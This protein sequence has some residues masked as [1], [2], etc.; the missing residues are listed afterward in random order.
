MNILLIHNAYTTFGGEDKVVENITKILKEKGHQ[1]YLFK[2]DSAEITNTPIGNVRAFFSG[3]YSWKSKQT[4]RRYIKEFKPDVVH[5]HNLYPLISP[6]I[7]G[8]CRDSGVP[9][10]MTVHNFRLICPNGLFLT[11]GQIC[12][13]CSGGREYWC[14]FRNCESNL[15]KSFGYA[16]RNIIA[17]K[18][19]FFLDN[20]TIYICLTEFQKQRF[21]QEGFPKDKIIVI[22]HMIDIEGINYPKATGEYVGYI[23]RISTE[24]GLPV[25]IEAARICEDIQFKAAGSYNQHPE[26]HDNAPQNFEF[27]GSLKNGLLDKFYTN[28]RFIVVP[29]IWYEVFGLVVLEAMIR[30]KVVICSRIGGLPE[31]VDDGVTGLLFEPSNAKELAEKIRYL[32]DRPQLCK[33]MGEAGREKAI[34]LYSPDKYYKS[35]MAVYEKAIEITNKAIN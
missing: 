22:P 26:L 17:R 10:V 34:Q 14:V 3:I 35:L 12:E 21:V 16:L 5:I 9:V 1:I 24:K 27:C 33:K 19:K 15:L 8:E 6:S 25:L 11:K 28:S 7:L 20:V 13:K 32:W 31:L 2:R 30:G 23:G 18:R 29:S 4:V